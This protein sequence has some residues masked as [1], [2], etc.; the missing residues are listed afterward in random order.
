[1]KL[2]FLEQKLELSEKYEIK[3]ENKFLYCNC[4]T[5]KKYYFICIHCLYI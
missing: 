5:Y 2:Y 4:I 1:M 3:Y